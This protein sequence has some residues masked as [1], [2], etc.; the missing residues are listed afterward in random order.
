MKPIYIFRKIISY[1]ENNHIVI[2]GY[3]VLQEHIVTKSIMNEKNRL[4]I[5]LRVNTSVEDIKI[6][7][8]LITSKPNLYAITKIKK[9]PKNFSYKEIMKEI[10]KKSL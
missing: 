5:F 10:E 4:E 1:L 8:N 6:L 2:P 3:S 7:E 9:E